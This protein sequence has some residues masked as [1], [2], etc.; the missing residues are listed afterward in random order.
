MLTKQFWMLLDEHSKKNNHKKGGIFRKGLWKYSR[1]PN[2][3]GEVLFWISMMFFGISA[4]LHT[5]SP[6]LV[7]IGPA[8]MVVFF[9]FSSWLMDVRSLERRP[10]YKQVMKEV[11]AMVPWF[12]K[13]EA[14]EEP[15][16]DDVTIKA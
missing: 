10:Q 9:R 7:F 5:T 8:L 6:V 2:Y 3:F 12:P 1:H 4:G 14:K 11:S 15:P 16:E 13:R